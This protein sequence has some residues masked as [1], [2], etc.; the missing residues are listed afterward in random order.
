[1]KKRERLIFII[2][3][4]LATVPM[5]NATLPSN[6]GI[7]LAASKRI[8]GYTVYDGK[9]TRITRSKKI[10]GRRYYMLQGHRGYRRIRAIYRTRKAAQKAIKNK[11]NVNN[12]NNKKSRNNKNSVDGIHISRTRYVPKPHDK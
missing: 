11:K 8:I 12:K 3:A 2:A 9:I 5:V 10:R 1:M 7:T 4:L 6:H